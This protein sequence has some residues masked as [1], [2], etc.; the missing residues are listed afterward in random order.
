MIA[1]SLS[2]QIEEQTNRSEGYTEESRRTIPVTT[3][4]L[5][6]PEKA[7]VVSTG[8]YF[9][10]MYMLHRKAALTFLL[11]IKTPKKILTYRKRHD[12]VSHIPHRIKIGAV[13]PR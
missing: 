6:Y 12:I 1:P 11:L 4:I 5:I 13:K 8:G 10:R 3:M 2:S 9:Q 7:R